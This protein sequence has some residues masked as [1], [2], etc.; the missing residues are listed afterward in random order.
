M[1]EGEKGKM[2]P[3]SAGAPRR[4]RPY[5]PRE[6]SCPLAESGK[7]QFGG[8]K[9]FNYGFMWGSHDYCRHPRQRTA[10]YN[11]LTGEPIACPLLKYPPKTDLPTQAR[12]APAR[13]RRVPIPSPLQP[14]PPTT[15]DPP[16]EAFRP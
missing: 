14:P 7:C 4:R 5:K 8:G 16:H 6:Y 13:L 15:E 10:V 9:S 3:P 2:V 11:S 12:S 1:G